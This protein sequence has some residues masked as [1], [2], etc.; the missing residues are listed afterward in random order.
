MRIYIDFDKI[1]GPLIIRNRMKGDKFIPLG[2]TGK[3]KLKDFFIDEKIPRDKRDKIPVV[4]CSKGIIWVA[5]YRMSEE[6]KTDKYTKK[7]L[8][9][10]M[11]N[12][13]HG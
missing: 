8:I 1:E 4:Q 3:K 10:E 11:E 7:T 2:M 12:V 5:G 6:Y 13:I 9:M